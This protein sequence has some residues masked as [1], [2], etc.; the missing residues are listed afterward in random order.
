MYNVRVKNFGGSFQVRIYENAIFDDKEPLAE[1]VKEPFSVLAE[2]DRE[3]VQDKNRSLYV[4][5]NR[6]IQKLY[7]YC[8]C[9]EWENFITLTFAP[10]C[11][12]DRFDFVDCSKT[13]RV[14]LNNQRRLNPDLKYCAVPEMH[15]NG[16][17]H[18]H[19]LT[20][21]FSNIKIKSSGLCSMGKRNY[22][23]ND[24]LLSL[25]AKEIFNLK[26][27][28]YGF[29]TMTYV[30]DSQKA[31]S[32]ITKYISKELICTL[33]NKH[34]YFVSNNLQL[35]EIFDFNIKSIGRLIDD[36][37]VS[38]DYYKNMY[39]DYSGAVFLFNFDNSIYENSIIEKYM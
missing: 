1:D 23:I 15:K 12:V 2:A 35:P 5:I 18:F 16:A 17:F 25:G 22:K 38:A 24:K 26:G 39:N 20:S 8:N 7:D 13:V 34:R 4:S 27:W 32:Y 37:L 21:N 9:N 10:D 28:R 14:W 29:S 6:T 31:I 19:I 33:P 11:K 36:L 3:K 30:A